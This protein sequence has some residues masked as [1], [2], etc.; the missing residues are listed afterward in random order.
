MTDEQLEKKIAEYHQLSRFVDDISKRIAELNAQ[1]KQELVDRT[2]HQPNAGEKIAFTGS[3]HSAEV[4]FRRRRV[5]ADR[6]ALAQLIVDKNLWAE[7]T[8]VTVDDDLVEQA[9]I[10]GKLTDN[11]LRSINAAMVTL[12]LKVT[13]NV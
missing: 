5:A 12:S 1:I 6:G 10:E 3:E 4:S 7:C 11:D 9:Y 13:P 8:R 2:D